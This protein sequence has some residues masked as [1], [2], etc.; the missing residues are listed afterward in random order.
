MHFTIGAKILGVAVMLVALMIGLSIY[1]VITV[2]R[3]EDRLAVAADSLIPL[4]GKVAA[5]DAAALEQEIIFTRLLRSQGTSRASDLPQAV[6]DHL[7]QWQ[8]YGTQVR[9][10]IAAVRVQI[11]EFLRDDDHYE[12]ALP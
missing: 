12:E 11:A 3:I 8:A 6:P 4:V 9:S 1:S 5:I 10:E 7:A 2:D